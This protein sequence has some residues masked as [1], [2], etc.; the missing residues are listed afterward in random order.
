MEDA[1]FVTGN[2]CPIIAGSAQAQQYARN[3]ASESQ[4]YHPKSIRVGSN[5]SSFSSVLTRSRLNNIVL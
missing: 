1:I 3:S 4:K 2:S 5:F